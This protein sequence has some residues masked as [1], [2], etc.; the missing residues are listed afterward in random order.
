M[1]SHQKKVKFLWPMK[2][3]YNRKYNAEVFKVI[4]KIIF[5]N[6]IVMGRAHEGKRAQG[7]GKP[8]CCPACSYR[9]F[10]FCFGEQRK[11]N[12]SFKVIKGLVGVKG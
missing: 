2:I 11:D 3:Y 12:P 9:S 6:D 7:P 1:L 5:N 4:P 10:S 8:S